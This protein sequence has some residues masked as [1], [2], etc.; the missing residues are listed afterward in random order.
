ELDAA[1][2]SAPMKVTGV[3]VPWREGGLDFRGVVGYAADMD[4]AAV[5]TEDGVVVG[6]RPP[7]LR[8]A[9]LVVHDGKA[10]GVLPRDDTLLA[11]Y[12]IDPG[13]ASYELEDL[14]AE[15]GVEL[16]RPRAP[17]EETAALV[18]RAETPRRLVGLLLQRL[19]ER[20]LTD[21]YR[22]VEL[23]LSNVL[24]QMERTGVKIDTYRM[25]EITAR[26]ADR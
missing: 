4:R 3:E 18:R 24:L 20:S 2:P 15:Y 19:E 25:G 7:E 26:L 11:A 9:D 17:D 13:R 10:L 6:A 22:R 8:E 5:A 14:A 16:V 21:L 23:P 1:V 12:L